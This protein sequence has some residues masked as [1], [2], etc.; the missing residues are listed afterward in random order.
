M[1][2][3]KTRS[4]HIRGVAER[5]VVP[6]LNLAA[7]SAHRAPAGCDA[8]CRLMRPDVSGWSGVRLGGRLEG[9]HRNEVWSGW[10]DG[11]RVVARV[12]R[13]NEASLVWELEL[14]RDLGEAGFLVPTPVVTDVGGLSRDG[15]VVQR[16]ID[17]REPH[18]VD[19]WALI[20]AELRRL[21]RH[22]ADRP[23]RPGCCSILELEPSSIS[24]DADMSVLPPDVLTDVLAAF[25]AFVGSQVTVIHG[26][27]AP[28]NLRIC[29]DGQ[30]GLLDWDE[31]RVDVS[32]LDLANLGVRVLSDDEH[33][34]VLI[35][36]DAWETANAW[37]AEPDY[38][39]RR[40]ADLRSRRRS[41][42]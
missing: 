6:T 42:G 38:A 41:H 24:V 9:G 15:V 29:A 17:G 33:E 12:S 10:L 11:E 35:A 4:S 7:R 34:R 8:S 18:C 25:A 22:C 31:S 40:L 36:A 21:H 20:A 2:P 14:L 30:V 23:Q 32:G 13:R 27:P 3:A 5:A 26:D 19:D 28:S 39:R 37:Q 16:W 1:R